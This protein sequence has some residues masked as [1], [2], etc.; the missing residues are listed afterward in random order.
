MSR[1]ALP[2]SFVS[3]TCGESSP[4]SQ[5][6]AENDAAAHLSVR[7][8][9]STRVTQRFGS[10]LSFSRFHLTSAGFAASAFLLCHSRPSS[11]PA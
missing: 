1:Q 9:T 2:W 5:R 6:H 8:L 3:A 7:G 10:A 11:V 4:S